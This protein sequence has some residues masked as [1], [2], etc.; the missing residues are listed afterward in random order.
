MSSSESE[1]YKGSTELVEPNEV[2]YNTIEFIIANN[3][4]LAQIFCS[5]DKNGIFKDGM[6]MQLKTALRPAS[7]SELEGYIMNLVDMGFFE[8]ELGYILRSMPVKML[9]K[10]K[11]GEL[12]LP[13][14]AELV[15]II[16][17][18]GEEKAL[19]RTW[20]VLLVPSFA[21]RAICKEKGYGTLTPF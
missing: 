13:K 12:K 7:K 2:V 5:I 9:K 15:E 6:L 18:K 1:G 19:I 21:L 20:K 3:K 8:I 16:N 10:N 4:Q 17:A 14:E 11:K